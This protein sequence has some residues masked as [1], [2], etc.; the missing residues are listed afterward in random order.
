MPLRQ[1][2]PPSGREA[3]TDGNNC[4]V[5]AGKIGGPESDV[6]IHSASGPSVEETAEVLKTSPER[7]MRDWKFAK[8]WWL[9]EL[10]RTKNGR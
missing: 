10:S 5:M 6:R 8:N 2:K 3:Q 4:H 9:R 7:V 1:S